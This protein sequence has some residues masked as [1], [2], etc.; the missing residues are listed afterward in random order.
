MLPGSFFLIWGAWWL[1][2]ASTEWHARARGARAAGHEPFCGRSWW[3]M[4]AHR[5]S[6]ARLEPRLK[7]FLPLAGVVV[8]LWF[9]PGN[10]YFRRATDPQTGLFETD[11]INNC[12][13]QAAAPP[14]V[15]SAPHASMRDGLA[16][17][18][19]TRRCTPCLHSAGCATCCPRC[20]PA[21]ASPAWRRRL[22]WRVCCSGAH[23]PLRAASWSSGASEVHHK[24]ACCD[25]MAAR[26]K[27]PRLTRLF[28]P[29]RFHLRM[30]TGVM[31]DVH[32]LLCAAIAGCAVAV[33]AEGALAGSGA[34]A[35]TAARVFFTLLQG[36]WFIQTARILYGALAQRCSAQCLLAPVASCL[37]AFALQARSR[38]T[39]K[40]RRTASCCPSYSRR[41]CLQA[42]SR[43]C[44]P[45]ASER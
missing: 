29:H 24:T 41:T 23:A 25:A 8:E 7:A 43:A 13:P 14:L 21:S 12:A 28:A 32:V 37:Q 20:P 26:R 40:K 42:R 18:G 17:Q 4:N 3:P 27:L 6:W 11:N 35:P 9:H 30:Q 22:P 16:L 36:T 33:A 5:R 31:A 2:A 19:S 38:G 34:F 10:V 45:A 39:P 1:L 15:S 44:M